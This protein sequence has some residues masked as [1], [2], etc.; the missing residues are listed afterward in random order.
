MECDLNE[1]DTP[2]KESLTPFGDMLDKACAYWMSIGVPYEEYWYGDYTRLKYYEEAYKV[3]LEQKNGELW[4]QGLYFYNALNAV[5]NSALSK[6]GEPPKKYLE[7]PIRI[8]ELSEDEQEKEKQEIVSKFRAQ[9]FEAGRR[10]EEKHKRE[11]E[12]K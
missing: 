4:L 10:F 9:L 1:V 3:K 11:R 12:M 6:K 2:Q 8:T 5:V 7:K